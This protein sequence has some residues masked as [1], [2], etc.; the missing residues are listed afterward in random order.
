MTHKY[1]FT[2]LYGL[3]GNADLKKLNPVLLLKE[4]PNPLKKLDTTI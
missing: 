3:G 4:N 1:D 2:Y